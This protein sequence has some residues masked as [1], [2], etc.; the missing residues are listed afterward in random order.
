MKP[1]ANANKV[2]DVPTNNRVGKTSSR[3]KA[4]F[5]KEE[6]NDAKPKEVKQGKVSP[7]MFRLDVPIPTGI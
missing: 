1:A 4:F 7:K 6:K 5:F 3:K 2:E